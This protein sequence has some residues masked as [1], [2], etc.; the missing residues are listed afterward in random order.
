MRADDTEPP[1]RAAGRYA[2]LVAGLAVTA[3]SMASGFIRAARGDV[4][5]VY[6]A[7]FLAWSGYLVAHYAATGAFVDPPGGGSGP[8]SDDF[9]KPSRATDSDPANVLPGDPRR[10]VGVLVGVAALVA[11]IA[12]L[13][14]YVRRG[15]HLLATAG[16][17]LFLAGYAVAHYFDHGVAL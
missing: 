7:G 17:G 12:V 5:G 4:L 11:G 1:T 2:V 3:A 10:A 14:F 13:A 15:D 6:V 9:E 16:G 8:D